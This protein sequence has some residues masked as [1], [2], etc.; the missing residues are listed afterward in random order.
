MKLLPLSVL[1]RMLPGPNGR[2]GVSPMTLLRWH[3][4]GLR[5]GTIKL[6]AQKVGGRWC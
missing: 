2:R 5:G 6:E 3:L 4:D 1:A